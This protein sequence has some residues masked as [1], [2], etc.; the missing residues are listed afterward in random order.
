MK[1]SEKLS[2]ECAV[3]GISSTAL[4]VVK[5][6]AGTDQNPMNYHASAEGW[7]KEQNLAYANSFQTALGESTFEEAYF[8]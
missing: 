4:K 1:Q 5:K 3:F 6:R 7:T 8:L 2:E